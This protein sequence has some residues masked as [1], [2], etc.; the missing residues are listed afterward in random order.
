MAKLPHL[1][2]FRVLGMRR[3]ELQGRDAIGAGHQ[4]LV[5]AQRMQVSVGTAADRSLSCGQGGFALLLLP[6]LDSN[7]P[8]RE[9]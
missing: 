4:V 8:R 1:F 9:V 2:H 7:G 3:L 6:M 5:S